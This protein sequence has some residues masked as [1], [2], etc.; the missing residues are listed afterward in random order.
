MGNERDK[1][2]RNLSN[3]DQSTSV[4]DA[5][6]KLTQKQRTMSLLKTTSAT[7]RK[8]E[9]RKFSSGLITEK[10]QIRA[11]RN[12]MADICS[13]RP[14]TTNS[15]NKRRKSNQFAD[16]SSSLRLPGS[17]KTL[18]DWKNYGAVVDNINWDSAA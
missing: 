1:I 15:V 4:R 11:L 7:P 9:M 8:I 10:T 6:S 18:D 13:S 2:A 3:R 14:V 17:K 12:E 16:T 5:R